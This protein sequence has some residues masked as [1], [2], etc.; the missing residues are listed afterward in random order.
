VTYWQA[1]GK[2][3]EIEAR[4]LDAMTAYQ[5]ALSFRPK[6]FKPR[7]GKKDELADNAE[8]LWKELG[9][10][11]LGWKAYLARNEASKGALETAEASAWDAKNQ[12]LPEFALADLQG[13]KWQLA[14]LKGKVAFINF[15]ATWCGPCKQELPYVQKLH[16]QMKENRDVVILTFNI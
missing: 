6:S 16:E 8:R 13:K 3:S 15:W 14:D 12:A 1:V 5:T 4:K 7:K 2:V 11:D 10:T 9:G